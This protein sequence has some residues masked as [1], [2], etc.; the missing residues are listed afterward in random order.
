[1]ISQRAWIE[2]P[3]P[4]I[5]TTTQQYEGSIDISDADFFVNALLDGIAPGSYRLEMVSTSDA[6]TQMCR[7]H[8]AQVD[9]EGGEATDVSLLLLC[10][11]P[12]DD[13]TTTGMP[14]SDASSLNVSAQFD[15]CTGMLHGIT[16]SPMSGQADQ[17]ITLTLDVDP[18]FSDI[19]WTT[20]SGTFQFSDSTPL[21]VSYSCS[22]PG[23]QTLT[24]TVSTDLEDCEPT[25]RDVMVTCQ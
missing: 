5:D 3:S 15:D 23:V 2:R 6:G 4:F 9:V 17:P 21:I 25:T 20:T 16:A 14:Q 24:A 19:D 11:A 13:G 10:S 18:G 12:H 8:V 22:Q 1:V 7:G